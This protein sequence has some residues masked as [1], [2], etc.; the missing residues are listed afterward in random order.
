[1]LLFQLWPALK[2]TN[3]SAATHNE[4]PARERFV[5]PECRAFNVCDHIGCYQLALPGNTWSTACCE[6][7]PSVC[8]AGAEAHKQ[9]WSQLVSSAAH[10]AC[11]ALGDV[12][13]EHR[14]AAVP[15]N[16]T[17]EVRHMSANCCSCVSMPWIALKV[18][19]RAT[20]LLAIHLQPISLS[21]LSWAFY[22]CV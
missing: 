4:L 8:A 19:A 11:A 14:K 7:S 5:A 16:A 3:R 9:L 6:P 10:V 20:S 13:Q 17:F 1:M 2:S 12:R 22:D 15:P 21:R 18:P